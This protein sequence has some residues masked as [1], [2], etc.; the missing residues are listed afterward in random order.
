[1]ELM[2][3]VIEVDFTDNSIEARLDR[4]ESKLD[5]IVTT[6]VSLVNE[7]KPILESLSDSPI[8]KMLGGKKKP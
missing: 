5:S 4:I 8:F 3:E 1:M 7:A 6:V 2:P